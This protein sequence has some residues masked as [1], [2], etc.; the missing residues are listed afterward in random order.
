[1]MRVLLSHEVGD[2]INVDSY[3]RAVRHL[4]AGTGGVV[5]CLEHVGLD[6]D[7]EEPRLPDPARDPANPGYGVWS[8][9]RREGGV[10]PPVVARALRVFPGADVP[11]SQRQCPHLRGGLQHPWIRGPLRRC[12][13]PRAPRTRSADLSRTRER[14][15]RESDSRMVLQRNEATRL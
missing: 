11:V 14:T 4:L 2:K 5:S 13:H 12:L 3:R 7:R 6:G 10:Q 8:L 15:I 1:M 9:G